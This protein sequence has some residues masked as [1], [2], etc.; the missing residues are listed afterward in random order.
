MRL[1]EK[2]VGSNAQ[3]GRLVHWWWL[4]SLFVCPSPLPIIAYSYHGLCG[5][6]A[7]SLLVAQL[8][9]HASLLPYLVPA[10]AIAEVVTC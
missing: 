8:S 3:C 4:V 6:E 1:W 9:T 2:Q 7:I 5:F 10:D